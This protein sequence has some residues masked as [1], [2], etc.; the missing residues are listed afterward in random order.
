MFIKCS[1]R[2]DWLYWRAELLVI[3]V[4]WHP[5]RISCY[6]QIATATSEC[7][8]ALHEVSKWA[9][10]LCWVSPVDPGTW[11]LS[12]RCLKPVACVWMFHLGSNVPG[13]PR[14]EWRPTRIRVVAST[15]WDTATWA[16]ESVTDIWGAVVMLSSMIS[17]LAACRAA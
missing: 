13:A 2:S 7:L 12:G 5:G 15:S 17:Q 9:R 6:Q 8:P 1:I 3:V 14:Y 10:W 4:R 11:S 16:E